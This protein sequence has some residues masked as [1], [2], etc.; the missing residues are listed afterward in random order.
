MCNGSSSDNSSDSF[1]MCLLMGG[2][3]PLSAMG[4]ILAVELRRERAVGGASYL[5]LVLTPPPPLIIQITVNLSML[6]KAL[7]IHFLGL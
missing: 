3:L 2:V 7:P 5:G 6:W 4:L 1:T